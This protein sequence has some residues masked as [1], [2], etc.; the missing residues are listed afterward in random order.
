[1]KHIDHALVAKTH[2]PM[3]LMHKY[4]ARKPHNVVQEYIKT[5]TKEGDI[6]FDPFVGSGPTYIESL[7][8]NRKAIGLDLDPMSIFITKCTVLP[9]NLEELKKEFE[10]IKGEI[11]PEIQDFYKTNCPNCKKER[12]WVYF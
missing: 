12:Y 1:M 5:Y 4:W 8:L 10:K 11:I 7:K 6:V 9:V 3:Y 2:T